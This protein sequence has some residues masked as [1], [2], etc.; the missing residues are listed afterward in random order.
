MVKNVFWGLALIALCFPYSLLTQ[1]VSQDKRIELSRSQ[2]RAGPEA[3]FQTE[4]GDYKVF[5]SPRALRG[6]QSEV[7]LIDKNLFNHGVEE[8][9]FNSNDIHKPQYE[10]DQGFLAYNID[11]GARGTGVQLN[12]TLYDKNYNLKNQKDINLCSKNEFMGGRVLQAGDSIHLVF[13]CGQFDGKIFR[14]TTIR[15]IVFDGNALTTLS[16]KYLTFPGIKNL[17]IETAAISNQNLYLIA[18]EDRLNQHNA[19]EE[20]HILLKFNKNGEEESRSELSLPSGFELLN[21]LMEIYQDEIY[22]IGEYISANT[23]IE[24][25]T[26]LRPQRSQNHTIK[27]IAEGVYLTKLNQNYE[28]VHVNYFSYDVMISNKVISGNKKFFK[29]GLHYN[30]REFVFIDDGSFYVVADLFSKT[31]RIKQRGKPDDM[32]YDYTTR[33][34]ITDNVVFHFNT[35]TNLEWVVTFSNKNRREDRSGLLKKTL[36]TNYNELDYFI[37]NYQDLALF[38]DHTPVISLRSSEGLG[39]VYVKRNGAVSG[40][41]DYS[42]GG[43]YRRIKHGLIQ[44]NNNTVLSV[45]KD[46]RGR[47][48]WLKRIVFR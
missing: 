46:K 47:N 31:W 3:A 36:P 48:I 30:L 8:V 26:D 37:I 28:T 15:H 21:A 24:Y 5:L 34:N 41:H 35:E 38:Y 4:N 1:E 18:T 11:E 32:D 23:P 40:P 33:F 7:L 44:E 16:E 22:I 19:I 12:L 6:F 39:C 43:D 27:N 10:V 45:G 13:Q 2:R 14:E 25:P 9:T 29:N 42:D 17:E 20:K